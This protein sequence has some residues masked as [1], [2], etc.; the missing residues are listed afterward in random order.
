MDVL[1]W[2]CLKTQFSQSA[3]T[4]QEVNADARVS[5]IALL[6]P[7]D[8][9]PLEALWAQRPG[10]SCPIVKRCESSVR[11]DLCEG[12]AQHQG[13]SLPAHMQAPV[14]SNVFQYTFYQQ[15]LAS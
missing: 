5:D 6:V 9:Q 8:T 7:E 12:V 15:H 11:A 2:A 13:T 10:T 14:P 3:F 1:D 4:L